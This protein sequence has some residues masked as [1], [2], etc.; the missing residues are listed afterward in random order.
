MLKR[1]FTLIE[2][3]VVI[4]IIA[5]LAGMLLPALNNAKAS[6][7]RSTCISQLKQL[8]TAETLYASNNQDY[9]TQGMMGGFKWPGDDNTRI[10][11]FAVKDYAAGTYDFTDDRAP[12]LSYVNR[13]SKVFMCPEAIKNMETGDLTKVS[14]GCGYGLNEHWLGSYGTSTKPGIPIRCSAVKD[15]GNVVMLAD[16]AK[17]ETGH[18]TGGPAMDYPTLTSPWLPY[19]KKAG[20]SGSIHF[21][22]HKSYASI[23]FVD[24]HVSSESSRRA[25]IADNEAGKAY[26]IG[27]YGAPNED[28]YRTDGRRDRENYPGQN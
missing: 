14:V 17:T 20:A 1:N 7:R 2:L 25:Q 13:S 9:F 23:A 11:W 21:G 27:F 24:G 26:L 12:L 6:A 22:R 15:P 16:S 5:I 19:S 4:A 8:H 18:G 28:F 10:Y 3:L